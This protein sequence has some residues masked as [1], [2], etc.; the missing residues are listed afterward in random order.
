MESTSGMV[1]VAGIT[2]RIVRLRPGE[3]AA[4]RIRDEREVGR[5]TTRPRLRVIAASIDGVVMNEIAWTALKA[6]KVSWVGRRVDLF[7]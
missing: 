6:A 2:Y 5:F 1:Q 7:R 3:Y 4:I